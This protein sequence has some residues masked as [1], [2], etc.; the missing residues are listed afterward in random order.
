M[1]SKLQS[2]IVGHVGD[3]Y[4]HALISFDREH[5]PEILDIASGGVHCLIHRAIA[6]EGACLYSIRI[7]LSE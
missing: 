6:L 3:G 1:E 7:R 2:T 5:H 4:F